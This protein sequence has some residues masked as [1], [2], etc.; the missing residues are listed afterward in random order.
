MKSSYKIANPTKVVVQFSHTMVDQIL[1]GDNCWR[2]RV[3][4]SVVVDGGI[5]GDKVHQIFASLVV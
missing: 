4:V 3:G 5:G 2:L 1:K